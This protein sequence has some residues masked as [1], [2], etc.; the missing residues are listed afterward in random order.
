MLYIQLALQVIRHVIIA[1]GRMTGASYGNPNRFDNS[2][3][4]EDVEEDDDSD[5]LGER[6]QHIYRVTN[7]GVHTV[8]GVIVRVTWPLKDVNG[9]VITYLIRKPYIRYAGPT[10]DYLDSCDIDQDIVD[11]LDLFSRAKRSPEAERSDRQRL[12]E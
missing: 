8:G 12:N 5:S 11:P 6:F 2:L 7:V 3:R 10:G 4:E 9:N 1:Q